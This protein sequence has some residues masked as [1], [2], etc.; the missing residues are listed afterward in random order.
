[1]RAVAVYADAVPWSYFELENRI[2]QLE[3]ELK[4]R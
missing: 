1:V 3:R 2:S 4:Y